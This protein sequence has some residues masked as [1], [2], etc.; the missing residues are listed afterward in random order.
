M[1]VSFRLVLP[2]VAILNWVKI[3]GDLDTLTNTA[4]ILYIGDVYIV[5]TKS[6]GREVRP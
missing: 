6:G 4:H 3:A 1:A 5:C 2:Q